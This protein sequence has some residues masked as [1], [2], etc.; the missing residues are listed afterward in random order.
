MGFCGNLQW[1][2]VVPN[3][4]AVVDVVDEVVDVVDMVDEVVMVDVA[5]V[6]MAP[7]S[8]PPATMTESRAVWTSRW[9]V[10]DAF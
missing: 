9:S 6:R 1:A 4:K 10:F 7:I 3:V 8:D 5:N 2:A